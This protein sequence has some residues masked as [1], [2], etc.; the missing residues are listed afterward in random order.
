MELVNVNADHR[1]T[2]E[3]LELADLKALI[4]KFDKL[5]ADK[6]ALG[7]DV[8]V[9]EKEG[10]RRWVQAKVTCGYRVQGTGYRVQGTGLEALGAGQGDE[11]AVQDD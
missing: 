8:F 1:F 9:K 11:G 6:F 2:K 10:S 4:D 7:C 5:A 3:A